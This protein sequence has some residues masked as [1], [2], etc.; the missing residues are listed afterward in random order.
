MNRISECAS[1][2]LAV[3]TLEFHRKL[4]SYKPR[5]ELESRQKATEVY[6]NTAFHKIVLPL[7]VNK[8][9]SDLPD[10]RLVV[11]ISGASI[12]NGKQC[13]LLDSMSL[14]DFT[15]IS[16]KYQFCN[17]INDSDFHAPPNVLFTRAQPLQ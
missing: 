17:F 14:T 12:R 4:A 13:F 10:F 16:N 2:M 6:L 15:S 5:S 8:S 11:M 7:L 1:H 9:K 3:Y